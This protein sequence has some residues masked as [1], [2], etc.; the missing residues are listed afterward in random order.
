[1]NHLA[2]FL[3]APQTDEATIGTLLADFH[4]GAITDALPA[5]VADFGCIARSAARPTGIRLARAEGGVRSYAPRFA[6]PA[7]DLYL[8]IASRGL[9]APCARAYRS[10]Q[11]PERLAIS[12]T[13]SPTDARLRAA[14]RDH[15][16]LRSYREFAGVE[17]AGPD[18]AP[19]FQ[20][21]VDLR[22][23]SELLRLRPVRCGVHGAGCVPVSRPLLGGQ[24]QVAHDQP[25][26][27]PSLR[28]R[29]VDSA[30]AE[31]IGD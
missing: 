1:M 8:I 5:A 6:G 28:H 27:A 22:L 13:T 19:P 9:A 18:A 10:S 24:R 30:R 29:L 21:E 31:V 26:V 16:W 2:H 3:L 11:Q 25:F 12:R 17:A 14:M 4:R 23:A 15:D 7:L 20:R